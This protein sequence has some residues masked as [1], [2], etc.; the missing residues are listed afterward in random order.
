MSPTPRPQH[1][2]VDSLRVVRKEQL[3]EVACRVQ[4]EFG[5]RMAT[6]DKYP[7]VR[8]EFIFAPAAA[9]DEE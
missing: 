2:L 1:T 3:M 4:A 9:A 5:F 7:R 6:K 8:E